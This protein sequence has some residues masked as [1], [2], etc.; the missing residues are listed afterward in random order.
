[1]KVEMIDSD[2]EGGYCIDTQRHLA[3]RQTI[4]VYIYIYQ[5]NIYILLFNMTNRGYEAGADFPPN[6]HALRL[7]TFLISGWSIKH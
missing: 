3:S 4:D 1:M 5:S 2:S 7:R 6:P